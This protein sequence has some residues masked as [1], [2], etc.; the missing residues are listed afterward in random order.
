MILLQVGDGEKLAM[1]YIYD[2]MD[3]AKEAIRSIYVGIEDK[4]RPIWEITNR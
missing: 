3:R 1:G 2:G 4:Y